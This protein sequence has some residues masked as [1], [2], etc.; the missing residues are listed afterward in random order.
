MQ[1]GCIELE[2]GRDFNLADYPFLKGLVELPNNPQNHFCNV[3]VEKRPYLYFISHPS[4]VTLMDAFEQC[5]CRLLSF[6]D[7]NQSSRFI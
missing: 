1:S 7:L 3:P 6:Y 5:G 2:T 4:L